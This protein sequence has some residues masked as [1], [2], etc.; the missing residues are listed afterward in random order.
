[1]VDVTALVSCLPAYQGKFRGFGSH[2]VHARKDFLLHERM[3]SGKRE[4]W[5]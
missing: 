4:I 3:I 2:R 5:S 1:M